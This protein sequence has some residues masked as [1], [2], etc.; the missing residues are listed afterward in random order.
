MLIFELFPAVMLVVCVIVGWVLWIWNR[1]ASG[2][3]DE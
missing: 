3:A 2:D 1:D